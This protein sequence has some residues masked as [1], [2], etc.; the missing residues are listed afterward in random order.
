M[1]SC[2]VLTPDSPSWS[3]VRLA[4]LGSGSAESSCPLPA[5]YSEPPTPGPPQEAAG[6]G[7]GGPPSDRVATVDGITLTMAFSLSQVLLVRP[8]YTC[9]SLP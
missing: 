6:L 8:P 4:V 1:T 9:G 2:G 5:T 3:A 7:R